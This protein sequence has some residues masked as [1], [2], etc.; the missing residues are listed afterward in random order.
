MRM[1]KTE[2]KI[3][4]VDD[5]SLNVE[6]LAA[7]LAPLN[8]DILTYASPQKALRELKNTKI[9][10][11]LIDI[12]MP[13]IDGF[14]FVEKFLKTHQN[15]PVIFVSA[16][17]AKENKIRGYNMGSFAY[18]EKPFDVNTIRAQI[19]SVLKLKKTQDELLGE[20]E[21]LDCIFKFSSNEIILTDTSF[22]I[23][24]QN[25]KILDKKKYF[26]KNFIDILKI[27]NQTESIE[28][29]NLFTNSEQ[30]QT[31][32]RVIIDGKKYIK[33]NISKILTES[34]ASGFLIVMDDRT[35]EIKIEQQ[36]ENFIE[37]LT[38]DLKTPVR[39]ETRALEL[40]YEGSFGILSLEQKDIIKEMLNSSHYMT[41]MTDNIL[42]RYK[43]ENGSCSTIKQPCSLKLTLE[44][45]LET[46]KYL[47]EAENKTIKLETDI[48]NDILEL[49]EREIK[50]AL[51]NII[52]NAAEY[53]PPHST[54]TISIQKSENS[55]ELSVKDEGPG[56][57][58][59]K[60]NIIF[61]EN[62]HINKRFK[63]VSS[64]LGLFITKRIMEAHNG[65]VNVESI[66][67]KGSKFTLVFPLHQPTNTNILHS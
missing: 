44:N 31:S 16:H 21:K 61:D 9:D 29:L 27:N 49:D 57:P 11:V 13:E 43:L 67:G 20:K 33:T 18:I 2:G 54:V 46:L 51:T 23:I 55:I 41:R 19:H 5:N 30:K 24:S 15:T 28:N 65:T 6:L 36:R 56:I 38:H 12:I 3:L 45:C 34:N 4:I 60:L 66:T 53:S 48:H 26:T 62:A 58:K 25:N 32:F 14:M 8:Y 17:T 1:E 7:T 10:A 47:F 59:D 64:G 39:A 42:L 50:I 22:N 63:K 52:A 40:L 35:E 37:T